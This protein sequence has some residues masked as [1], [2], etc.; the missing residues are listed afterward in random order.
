[1]VILV[2]M[3]VLDQIMAIAFASVLLPATHSI[4]DN[5]E[6]AS[7]IFELRRS[8]NFHAMDRQYPFK[9]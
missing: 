8:F 6:K 2:I 3:V 5:E 7:V 1:M 4:S 9:M